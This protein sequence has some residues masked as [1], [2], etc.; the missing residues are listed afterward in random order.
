MTEAIL[1]WLKQADPAAVYLMLFLSSF[2]E[3]IVPPLPGDV[4]IAFAGYLLAFSRLS[5]FWALFW[6]T[7]GSTGGF[8]TVYFL[9]RSLGLK[10]YAHG[11]SAAQHRFAQRVLKMF[12]PSEMEAVRQK[13]SK[14]GYTAVLANRFFLG[15]RAVISVVAGILHLNALFVLLAALVSATLWNVMLLYGG[16]VLGQNWQEIGRYAVLYSIPVTI[17]FFGFV[18]YS[19]VKYVRKRK[20][21]P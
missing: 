12:P 16:L 18:F 1:A 19:V 10:I 14:H 13:F 17:A 11:E 3:N 2:V 8:M 6:S 7:F 15:S 20:R 4:P 9:S 5:F 21:E